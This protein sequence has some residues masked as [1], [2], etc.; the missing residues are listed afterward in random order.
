MTKI[1]GRLCSLYFVIT[2]IL[3]FVANFLWRVCLHFFWMYIK[4]EMKS[5]GHV[6][7]LCL[8]FK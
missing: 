1:D 8:I 6:M 2:G 4:P 7:A 5:L 3:T